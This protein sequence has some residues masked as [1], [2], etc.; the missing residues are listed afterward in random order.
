MVAT[1]APPELECEPAGPPAVEG[2]RSPASTVRRS[3]VGLV[4]LLVVGNLAIAGVSAWARHTTPVAAAPGVTGINNFRAVDARL[5]RGA[6]PGA[7]GYRSLAAAGVRTV[8]DLRAEDDLHIDDGLLAELGIERLA[9]PMRDGQTPTAAELDRF[10][11]TVLSSDSPVFVHCGAG[12]GR[13]G[14]MVAAYLVE[15]GQSNEWTAMRRNLAVGPP[16]L[17][18]LAFVAGLDDGDRPGLLLTAVSRV[19]DA[20]RRLWSRLG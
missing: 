8:V 2:S 12:V 20:P 9:I 16:S 15:T 4:A 11:A 17:E 13:T 19:L 14:T 18:Q 10:L 1:F 3:L 6:A 7:R 5:W